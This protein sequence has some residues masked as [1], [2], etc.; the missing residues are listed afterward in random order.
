MRVSQRLVDSFRPPDTPL[1]VVSHHSHD[2][3]DERQDFRKGLQ[4][5]EEHRL[6]LD[7]LLP[8]ANHEA[9]G[10]HCEHGVQFR[11]ED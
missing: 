1:L 4:D 11:C 6:Y 8:D 2:E 9:G 7:E 10:C 3:I 5:G